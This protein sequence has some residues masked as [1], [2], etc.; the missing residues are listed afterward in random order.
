ME[1]EARMRSPVRSAR[2]HARTRRVI[3]VGGERS[4]SRK[5]IDIRERERDPD[6]RRDS[7]WWSS[8]RKN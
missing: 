7:E 8:D 4:K 3:G 1:A 2:T 5:L 6:G